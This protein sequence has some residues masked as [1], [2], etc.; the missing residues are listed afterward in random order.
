MIKVCEHP[1]PLRLN[2]QG[3]FCPTGNSVNPMWTLDSD[4]AMAISDVIHRVL[5]FFQASGFKPCTLVRWQTAMNKG[6]IQ[7]RESLQGAWVWFIFLSRQITMEQIW[8][9]ML[10][11]HWNIERFMNSLDGLNGLQIRGRCPVKYKEDE[12][13]TTSR[14]SVTLLIIF[15]IK[16]KRKKKLL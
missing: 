16:S 2:Q 1:M 14:L 6:C 12:C 8:I 10:K 15:H 9:M 4:T 13:L 5:L 11:L 3:T 7:T